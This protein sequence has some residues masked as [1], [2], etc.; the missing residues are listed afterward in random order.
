[1]KADELRK[2]STCCRCRKPIGHTGLPLFWRVS[3]ER[4]GVDLQAVRR[5]SGL[6]MMLGSVPLAA[7][8]GPDEEVASPVMEKVT[9]T[10]CEDCALQ[11]PTPVAM[12]A[13]LGTP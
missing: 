13:E 8:M 6:E 7:A 2:A 3:I 5:Q 9:V 12:L 4:F 10:V 1:M 11:A